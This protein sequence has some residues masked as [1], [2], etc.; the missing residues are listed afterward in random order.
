MAADGGWTRE[1]NDGNRRK[2]VTGTLVRG[3]YVGQTGRLHVYGTVASCGVRAVRR[4][5]PPHHEQGVSTGQQIHDHGTRCCF[6][7]HMSKLE[8]KQFA[9]TASAA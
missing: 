4:L 6:I 5:H 3:R 7:P 2:G 9:A 8:L 1:M